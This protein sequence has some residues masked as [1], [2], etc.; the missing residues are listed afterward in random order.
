MKA[1][2]VALLSLILFVAGSVPAPAAPL[3]AAVKR[4]W[5]YWLAPVLM[6]SFLGIAGLLALGYVVR[7]VM[8]KYGIR[9]G[10]RSAG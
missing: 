1:G 10:R 3:L 7:V 9:V 4:P 8:A 6:L 2:R 5:H